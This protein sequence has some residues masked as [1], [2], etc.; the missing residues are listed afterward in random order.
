MLRRRA[1]ENK[2]LAAPASIDSIPTSANQ[3][4]HVSMATHA[5]WRLAAMNANTRGIVAIELMAAAE[6]I[7]FR[8]PLRSS[9]TLEEAHALIRA[10]VAPRPEDRV[11]SHDIE[12][13]SDLISAGAFETFA[14]RLLDEI[15]AAPRP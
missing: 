8:R 14:G 12:A 15:L 7:E 4:D 1:S 5:A 10:H 9:P 3:E 11:F 13:V 2:Q 6:G